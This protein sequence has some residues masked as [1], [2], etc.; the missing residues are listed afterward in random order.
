MY[1]SVQKSIESVSRLT[2]LFASE[3]M[4]VRHVPGCKTASI[5][6]KD[7]VVTLPVWK[8]CPPETMDVLTS[9]EAYG[10]GIN[11]PAEGLHD[12]IMPAGKYKGKGYK[13]FLN[14]VED[15]RIEKL[16]KRHFP[17]LKRSYHLGY[18][19]MI[20][21][22]FFGENIVGRLETMKL[23]DRFNVAAKA[24]AN[25]DI[26]F[27]GDEAVYWDRLMKLETFDQAVAL[28]DE[29]FEKQK[30]ENENDQEDDSPET[31]SSGE[32]AGE[33][34]EGEPEESEEDDSEDED[35]TETSGSTDEEGDD[36]S[37]EDDDEPKE[38]SG[39]KSEEGED[40]VVE[41][42]VEESDDDPIAETDELFTDAVE[43][44]ADTNASEIKYVSVPDINT[45]LITVPWNVVIEETNKYVEAY[46]AE[47][48]W[49]KVDQDLIQWR[50]DNNKAINWMV[51]EFEMKKAA[52]ELSRTRSSKSGI[53]DP[54]KLHSY[55]FNDDIF[56]KAETVVGG[57]NHGL[58]MF[59]DW[60]G[61]MTTNMRGT[62]EQL[63]NLVTFC[64]RVSIPFEVYA[65][66]DRPEMEKLTGGRN[67]ID[68]QPF[69]L[70]QPSPKD[71]EYVFDESFRLMNMFS[72]KMSGNDF[73]Q[74]MKTMM[75]LARRAGGAVQL[76][77][78]PLNDTIIAAAD[79]VE[80][81]TKRNNVQ[82]VN[83]VFLTDGDSMYG[84]FMNGEHKDHVIA[85]SYSF[86]N[87]TLVL[88]DKKRGYINELV[89]QNPTR[90]FLD[91]F[92]A[93][94]GNEVMG[95]FLTN[96]NK[97]SF[98]DA[99][100][101]RHGCAYTGRR[102]QFQTPGGQ[103]SYQEFRSANFTIVKDQ[104]Y[105]ELYFI[106][107]GDSLRSG[108]TDLTGV[109]AQSTKGQVRKAFMDSTKGLKEKRVLLTRFVEKIA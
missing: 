31:D 43:Q 56:A 108:N 49:G 89:D 32:E 101:S 104:G 29:L 16:T 97:K 105:S 34:E 71:G 23:I 42:D 37:E 68:G 84:G 33:P 87:K 65:F 106:A 79:V 44:M 2:N 77:G 78:T 109:T 50:A 4:T 8:D 102:N 18:K 75:M 19:W 14:I 69:N 86:R 61:S 54:L 93:V 88:T 57:K 82:V 92:R 7:R 74:M 21:Q 80:R 26:S 100:D 12:A 3:N 95:F 63:L 39:G 13:S 47:D 64:R 103:E 107:D 76:G 38:S 11:T 25:L 41:K 30:E 10:H 83:T 51:K 35:D 46:Y 28:A 73:R 70:M 60:S 15:A 45:D 6:L 24:G 53:L 36:D 67:D 91:Y 22:N 58:V 20:E 27:E 90:Q 5:N 9:H 96:K 99:F 40:S 85:S 81:F 66:T 62:I 98:I 1:M 59:I 55:Q 72:S 94:S 48:V 52:D 17:G